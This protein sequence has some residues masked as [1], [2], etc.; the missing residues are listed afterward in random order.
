V[1]LSPLRG[2]ACGVFFT[3]L[4]QNDNSEKTFPVVYNKS[5]ESKN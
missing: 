1:L 3:D 4:Q 2:P 5:Q